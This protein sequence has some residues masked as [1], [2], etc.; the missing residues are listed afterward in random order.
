MVTF[1]SVYR[2][3]ICSLSN[4]SMNFKIVPL[5]LFHRFARKDRLTISCP[6]LSSIS[7]SP[8]NCF[9][10]S[11]DAM[12]SRSIHHLNLHSSWKIQCSAMS[13][14]I[15]I[16]PAITSNSYT[17]EFPF[18]PVVRGFLH[19]LKED[20]IRVQ[21]SPNSEAYLSKCASLLWSSLLY[22]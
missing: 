10:S 17:F 22:F 5:A 14:C 11:K 21:N 20:S 16:H 6:L 1:R 4:N 3:I 7:L 8:T 15:F 13:L 2:S 9:L 12:S 19:P 18:L